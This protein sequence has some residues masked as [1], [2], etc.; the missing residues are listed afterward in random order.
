M[1]TSEPLFMCIGPQHPGQRFQNPGLF[2]GK[3]SQTEL[4]YQANPTTSVSMPC[5]KCDLDSGSAALREKQHM[6]TENIFF[7]YILGK[8]L[9]EPSSIYEKHLAVKNISTAG[10]NFNLKSI[11]RN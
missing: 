9:G 11:V 8:A 4:R 1:M 2:N 6:N 3:T 10:R 7:I 5:G